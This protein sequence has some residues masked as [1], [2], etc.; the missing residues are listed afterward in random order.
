MGLGMPSG[1]RPP[2]GI[3]RGSLGNPAIPDI[4]AEFVRPAKPAMEVKGFSPARTDCARVFSLGLPRPR[5]S[6]GVTTRDNND[7]GNFP[8]KINYHILYFMTWPIFNYIMSMSY[9]SYYIGAFL[10]FNTSTWVIWDYILSMVHKINK[11]TH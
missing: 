7:F 5:R 11:Q 9:L 4:R 2:N 6:D 1:G 8:C 3:P 10:G